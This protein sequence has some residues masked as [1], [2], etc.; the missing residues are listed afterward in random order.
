MLAHVLDDARVMPKDFGLFLDGTWR[1]HPSICEF[2]SEVFYEDNL[3]P[4]SRPGEL[5][6]GRLVPVP[7]NGAA[8]R[9]GRAARAPH[10]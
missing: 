8:L 10:Q 3:R 4:H 6:P 7:R 5:G 9:V 2:T 1:L